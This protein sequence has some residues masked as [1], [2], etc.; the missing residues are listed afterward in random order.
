VNYSRTD[1]DKLTELHD[2]AERGFREAQLDARRPFIARKSA[3]ER[4]Q[5][6][7]ERD[8][9]RGYSINVKQ[10]VLAFAVEFWIIGLIIVGTYLL[11]AES[12]QRGSA[13]HEEVFSALLLPAALAMVELARVPL[14]IAVRTQTSWHIK[15]FAAL[16]VIAAITVTSFSLS[17][18]AWKTFD[19]RTAEA[20]RASDK[21]AAIKT[22]KD[23]VQNKI[24]QLQHDL[25]QKISDRNVLNDR[26]SL[27][28]QQ[29]TQI[30]HSN[31]MSCKPAFGPDGKLSVGDD[32]KPLQ[33][34]TPIA[35]VN[36]AQF[37][38]LKAQIAS[39]QKEL[40]LAQST[41]KQSEEDV[42]LVD[43]KAVDDELAKADAEYRSAV[44]TSQLYSY[45]GMLTGK[46]GADVTEADVKRLEKYLIIIPSIA[47]AF[48]STL[49]AVTAVRR[50]RAPEPQ[51][52]TTIPDEAAKYLFGPLLEA[53]R[54]EARDSVAAAMNGQARAA[55]PPTKAAV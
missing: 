37:G 8:I 40:E 44:D 15:F 32:G 4:H 53:I 17:Q 29:L 39:T 22:R 38:L 36:Q 21:V 1:T 27:L 50:L 51:P 45:A 7:L 43:S 6:R 9:A 10:V 13:S 54:A 18:I 49:L 12:S 35:A 23:E 42:R 5:T 11:I 25:A 24:A 14:A 33:S 26:L 41:V 46:A 48:A 47:A 31:G 2:V 19:I 3:V 30:S 28:Q 20:T 16:G 55:A 52:I 34:C